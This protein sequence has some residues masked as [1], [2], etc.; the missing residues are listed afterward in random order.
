MPNPEAAMKPVMEVKYSKSGPYCREDLQ[1]QFS[2]STEATCGVLVVRL[3][4]MFSR[5]I[6]LDF[7]LSGE[8][9]KKRM[10]RCRVD[11]R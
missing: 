5:Q 11:H 10:R 3:A 9:E 7:F 6:F 1:T 4:S 8:E 2:H